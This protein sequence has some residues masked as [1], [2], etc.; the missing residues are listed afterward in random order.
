MYS[1]A[2]VTHDIF[3]RLLIFDQE[4]GTEYSKYFT[5]EKIDIFVL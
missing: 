2:E 1:V 3:N 4:A 5:K